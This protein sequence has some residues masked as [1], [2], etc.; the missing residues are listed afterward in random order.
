MR[1]VVVVAVPLAACGLNLAGSLPDSTE[2]GGA[3]EAAPVDASSSDAPDDVPPLPDDASVLACALDAGATVSVLAAA[4]EVC[5]TGTTESVV[6]TAPVAGAGACTCGT[7]TSTKNPT[8]ST[9]A[10]AFSAGA[11]NACNEIS[12]THNNVTDN[13]CTDFGAGGAVTLTGFHRWGS[14]APQAGTCTAASMRDATK[15][16]TTMLKECAPQNAKAACDALAANA[17]VCIERGA[18]SCGGAFPVAAIVGS[19]GDVACADCSC[20]R[21]ASGCVADYHGNSNCGDGVKHTHPLNNTCA[22]TNG[23]SGVAYFKLRA[24]GVTC[25]ATAGAATPTLKNA[26]TLCCTR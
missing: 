12:R 16:T 3:T 24:S 21:G 26:R 8:C 13:V 25:V 9:A 4:N 1:W 18:G 20:V 6:H 22:G 19:G 2:D 10:I 15:V 23:A 14:L 11:T 5:P 17:R 7:C